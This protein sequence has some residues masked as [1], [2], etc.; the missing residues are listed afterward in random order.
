MEQPGRKEYRV[1][2]EQLVHKGF[3]AKL[4]R[5]VKKV[6]LVKQD[7]KDP[8]GQMEPTVKPDNKAIK[9]IPVTLGQLELKALKG[10]RDP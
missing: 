10:F 9:G 6:T 5:K 4:D 7:Y 8:Q 2:L 1:I 3:K